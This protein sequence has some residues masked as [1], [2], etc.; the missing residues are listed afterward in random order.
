MICHILFSKI[1]IAKVNGII[2][3]AKLIWLL[4]VGCYWLLA[5]GSRAAGFSLKATS[6][7]FSRIR[8]LPKL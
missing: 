1:R 5:P 2:K 7:Q 8:E 4:A 6:G 3:N